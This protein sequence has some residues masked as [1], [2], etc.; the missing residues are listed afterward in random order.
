VHVARAQLLV[1]FISYCPLQNKNYILPSG[2]CP[3]NMHSRRLG[4]CSRHAS[5][6]FFPF[7]MSRS[8]V[9]LGHFSGSSSTQDIAALTHLSIGTTWEDNILFTS[10][11]HFRNSSHFQTCNMLKQVKIRM[12]IERIPF[13]ATFFIW[14]SISGPKS[15]FCS[16]LGPFLDLGGNSVKWELKWPFYPWHV[17]LTVLCKID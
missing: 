5:P 13:L 14:T 11:L 9:M 10:V 3:K 1:Y 17:Q 12:Y 8:S 16:F 15:I 2:F 4:T 7:I 6:Q